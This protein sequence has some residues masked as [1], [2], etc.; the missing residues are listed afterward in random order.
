[1]KYIVIVFIIIMIAYVGNTKSN[2]E[3]IESNTEVV[4]FG[5]TINKVIEDNNL[6]TEEVYFTDLLEMI[7]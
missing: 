5:K 1:M 2:I 6:Q 3:R 7:K 4:G